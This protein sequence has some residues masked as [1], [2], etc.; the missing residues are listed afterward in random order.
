MKIDM[1]QWH[2]AQHD[3]L[4][5]WNIPQAMLIEENKQLVYFHY[6]GIESGD[7]K[8][9]SILDLGGGMTSFLLRCKN[10][11]HDSTVV[12]PIIGIAPQWVRDRYEA[13][14]ILTLSIPAEDYMFPVIYDE[15]WIY[16]VLQHVIDPEAVV[17]V[18][19]EHGKL[20]RIFEHVNEPTDSKHPH[21]F[22]KQALDKL[23]GGEGTVEMVD[24]PFF[25]GESYYGVFKV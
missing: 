5:Y 17:R 7:L 20:I 1:N 13:Q 16:N 6:M 3:E 22:D 18:A 10:Y 2:K 25:K 19:K 8:G 14:G 9:K 12:D 21:T 24:T 23:M 11:A 15:V 4:A